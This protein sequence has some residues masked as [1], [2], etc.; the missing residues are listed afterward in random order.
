MGPGLIAAG[1]GRGGATTTAASAV[2]P[3]LQFRLPSR[4]QKLKSP[5]VCQSRSSLAGRVG[6]GGAASSVPP[7]GGPWSSLLFGLLALALPLRGALAQRRATSASAGEVRRRRGVRET[8]APGVSASVTGGSSSSPLHFPLS[9]SFGSSLL[10][11]LFREKGAGDGHFRRVLRQAEEAEDYFISGD[12]SGERSDSPEAAPD[13]KSSGGHGLAAFRRGAENP[14]EMKLPV[15]LF[16]VSDLLLI[17]HTKRMHL[18]EPRWVA[19][20]DAALAD[21]EG[22]L[23]LVYFDGEM[24]IVKV[25]TIAEI[26][27]INT[28]GVHG[29]MVTVRGVSRGQL[30]GLSSQVASGDEWGV[31]IC[32]ELAEAEAPVEAEAEAV[33][34]VEA[35]VQAAFGN[36][37]RGRQAL[38]D[39]EAKAKAVAEE[40]AEA[41]AEAEAKALVV[42]E[43]GAE[44]EAVAEAVAKA[45]ALA[46]AKAKAEEAKAKAE[47]RLLLLAKTEEAEKTMPLS[48]GTGGGGALDIAL[49]LSALLADLDLTL[50]GPSLPGTT[51]ESPS[52]EAGA[53][54]QAPALWT[55]ERVSP[56]SGFEALQGGY[57]PSTLEKVKQQLQGVPLC[58][59]SGLKGKE[60]PG[61]KGEKDSEVVVDF[62]VVGG[63]IVSP[64][65]VVVYC[66]C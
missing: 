32:E 29:R 61:R 16:P 23:G 34:E 11:G 49:R 12:R 33:A 24:D 4:L 30:K 51:G 44:A 8:K 7:L 6:G 18:Y 60:N 1:S 66:C 3:Q 38:A 14:S 35:V 37:I 46:D 43:A 62:V 10:G 40:V 5:L 21:F 22:V 15:I 47:L 9:G 45:E 42:V 64:V 31:A 20:V 36:N 27:S 65:V 41:D 52:K 39:A 17:G 53:E 28:L 50:S 2:A 57:W 56:Y 19:M 55:H 26:V 63:V 25:C 13:T 54:A 58:R 59:G 48:P